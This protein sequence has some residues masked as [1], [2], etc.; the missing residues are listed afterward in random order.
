MQ[1][2]KKKKMFWRYGEKVPF[3]QIF[4]GINLLDGF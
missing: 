3:R 4:F 1:N 2:L